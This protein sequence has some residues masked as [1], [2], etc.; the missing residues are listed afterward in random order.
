MDE[1]DELDDNVVPESSVASIDGGA[2]K[3]N[4]DPISDETLDSIDRLLDE[5]ELTESGEENQDPVLPVEQKQEPAKPER[6]PQAPV[7]TTPEME[8]DPEILA[9]EQPRNLSEKN[10]SNWRKLQETASLY[11]Q[12]AQE[13][14]ILRQRLAEAESRPPEA[15][16][17]YEE[18]RKFRA[19]FDIKNDPEFR[20]KY[21]ETISKAKESVYSILK[22]H[23][24]SDEV[25]KSI[26]D[27]G[28]PDKVSDKWWQENALKRLPLTDAERLKRG[29]IDITDLKERQ[30]A[31]IAHAA[32]NA[33]QIM[34]ERENASKNWYDNETKSV[35]EH[36]ETLTKD[37]PWARYKQASANATQ[38]Q[39]EEIRA[40]NEMVQS[41]D[42]KFNSALWPKTAQE[43]AS[44]AAA[45]VFSHVLTEQ[46]RAEQKM[47]EDLQT[48]LKRATDEN[49]KLKGASRVPRQTVTTQ[50]SIKANNLNDRL[51]MSSEQAIDLGIDEALE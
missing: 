14:E 50:S 43:R 51:K 41:L 15:P 22:K 5:V 36:I 46:L 31:E 2:E 10:Q 34:L 18:L 6:E 8:I 37:I 30:D 23:G 35:R 27:V 47:R 40:H 12:Q 48:Q 13:A 44:I 42:A 29:L 49:A 9:I 19:I 4:A 20:S 26:E 1:L 28:G 7:E 25:I 3:L 39:Q 38:G 11:K 17:D 33:E 32:E 16:S 45:A 24:A 21:T